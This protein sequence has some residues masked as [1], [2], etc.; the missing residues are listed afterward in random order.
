MFYTE[1]NATGIKQLRKNN[2]VFELDRISAFYYKKNRDIY[3]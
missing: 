2:R 1:V 3:V